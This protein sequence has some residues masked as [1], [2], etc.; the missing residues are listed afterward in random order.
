MR[1]EPPRTSGSGRHLSAAFGA[2]PAL[3]NAVLH[4]ADLLAAPCAILTHVGALAAGV[5][6]VARAEEHEVRRG[7]AHLGAGEHQAEVLRLDVPPTGGQAVVGCHAEAGLVAP[8]ALVDARLHVRA[9]LV[10]CV[11]RIVGSSA[12]P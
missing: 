2:A 7:A 12:K 4:I 8:Q 5:P 9:H 3:V 11:A 1:P 6:M 10:H